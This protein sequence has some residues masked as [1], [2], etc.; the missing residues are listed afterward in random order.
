[1]EKTAKEVFSFK[2]DWIVWK[3]ENNEYITIYPLCFKIDWI[4]WKYMIVS[5][6]ESVDISL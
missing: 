3:Y 5:S 6:S 4:V 1:M 2:I